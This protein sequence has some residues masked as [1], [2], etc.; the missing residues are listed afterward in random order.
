MMS[1]KHKY[2]SDHF[3]RLSNV[4]RMYFRFK[5]YLD[6]LL[7][8]V[9]RQTLLDKATLLLWHRWNV[10]EETESDKRVNKYM[11]INKC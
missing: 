4:K 2:E 3:I 1:N 9:H 8:M 10:D 5:N 7:Q 6:D 11:S